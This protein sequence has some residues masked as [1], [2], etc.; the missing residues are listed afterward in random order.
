MFM[1]RMFWPKY[2]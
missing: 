2:W 1:C